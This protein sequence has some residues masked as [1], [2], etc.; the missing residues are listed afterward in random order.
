[1]DLPSTLFSRAGVG[2]RPCL[3]LHSE[4][5][6]APE[7][8]NHQQKASGRRRL[9]TSL[10]R[11]RCGSLGLLPL[12]SFRTALCLGLLVLLRFWRSFSTSSSGGCCRLRFLL[13]S[14][15]SACFLCLF[16]FGGCCRGWRCFATFGSRRGGRCFCLLLLTSST[17]GTLGFLLSSGSGWIGSRTIG[18]AVFSGSS[19]RRSGGGCCCCSGILSLLL[20]SR[21]SASLFFGLLGSFVVRRSGRRRC[22]CSPARGCCCSC[23]LLGLPL[24]PGGPP[25]LLGF[26]LSCCGRVRVRRA[27]RGFRGRS[28]RGSW[29]RRWLRGG[30]HRCR[31]R[32]CRSWCSH[33]LS[34]C[35]DFGHWCGGGRGRLRHRRD[36]RDQLGKTGVDWLHHWWHQRLRRS[37]LVCINP[38]RWA[39]IRSVTLVVATVRV[40]LLLVSGLFLF[41]VFI[42]TFCS[43]FS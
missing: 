40:S 22:G 41:V 13:F 31:L 19:R 32:H 23:C 3:G 43:S 39:G 18:D 34:N 12:L 28:G 14:S 37:H 33:R 15:G 20:L 7:R 35:G 6:R 17:A 29:R 10:R 36:W 26:S 9:S 2:Q 27:W 16:I 21:R 11:C 25:C 30:W 24:L 8:I 1:M 4:G 42:I 5:D 38:V